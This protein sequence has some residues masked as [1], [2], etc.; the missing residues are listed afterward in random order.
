MAL[1]R[2]WKLHTNAC[3][4]QCVVHLK[5]TYLHETHNN[6]NMRCSQLINEEINIC[7]KK[8]RSAPKKRRGR[9]SILVASYQQLSSAHSGHVTKPV[10]WEPPAYNK[11]NKLDAWDKRSRLY[12]PKRSRR[13]APSSTIQHNINTGTRFRARLYK[14][15]SRILINPRLLY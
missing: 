13:C 14:P 10:I 3:L 1:L 7:G 15:E 6:T 12:E 9:D 2:S 5:W 11:N 8:I 4:V